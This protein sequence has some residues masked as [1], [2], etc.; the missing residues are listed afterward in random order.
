M[1][2]TLPQ[3]GHAAVL[4]GDAESGYDY[5][6]YGFGM[7]IQHFDD[8]AEAKEFL[9]KEGYDYYARFFQNQTDDAKSRLALEFGNWWAYNYHVGTH[10]CAHAASSALQ[11]GLAGRQSCFRVA[12]NYEPPNSYF[13]LIA[14]WAHDSGPIENLQEPPGWVRL[15]LEAVH[16]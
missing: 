2:Q 8:L 9:T 4:V 6:S 13:E 16:P 5:Y 15:L 10:N 11:T 14:R 1:Q 12:G 7:T 3:L